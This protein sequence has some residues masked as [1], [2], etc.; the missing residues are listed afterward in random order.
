MHILPTRSYE[1]KS[2]LFPCQFG[3]TG[4]QAHGG[5]DRHAGVKRPDGSVGEV[6]SAGQGTATWEVYRPVP[7]S[8]L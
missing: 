3:T 2:I 8:L 6:S 4:S 1:Y 5:A 7:R